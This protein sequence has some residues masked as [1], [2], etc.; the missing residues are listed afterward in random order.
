[1]HT[2]LGKGERSQAA[3]QQTALQNFPTGV[4]SHLMQTIDDMQR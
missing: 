4:W 2:A 1:M 3:S